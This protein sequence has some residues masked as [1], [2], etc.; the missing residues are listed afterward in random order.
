MKAQ[1]VLLASVGILS[2]TMQTAMA[3]DRDQKTTFT[4]SGPVEIPGQVL[5]PGTYVFKIADSSVDRN[6]VQVYSKDEKRLVGT[7]LAIS[8]YRMKPAGKPIIT[9][10]ERP[11]GSP[12]AVKAWFYPGESYGH[13]FVYPK[14]KAVALAKANAAPVPSMPAELADNTTMPASNMQEP[15]VVALKTAPLKAQKPTEEEVEISEI[16]VLQPTDPDSPAELPQT[17]SNLPLIG[18][19]GFLCLAAGLCVRQAASK[20]R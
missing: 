13:D 9:F 14:P 7:F 10:D 5:P 2:A 12:E 4:F 18:L 16:F 8:D 19:G 20:V 15:Q 3:S 1:L 17:A 11:E 6:V